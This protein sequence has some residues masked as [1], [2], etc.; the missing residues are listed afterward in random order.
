MI[1]KGVPKDGWEYV[2]IYV[3]DT[4]IKIFSH[5]SI[6]VRSKNA[7]KMFIFFDFS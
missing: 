6:K 2:K 4:W 1:G 5:I 7:K 3:H